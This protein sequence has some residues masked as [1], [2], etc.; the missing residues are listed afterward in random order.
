MEWIKPESFKKIKTVKVDEERILIQIDL[1]E[2]HDNKLKENIFMYWLEDGSVQFHDKSL[3]K[4]SIFGLAV[5][6]KNLYRG[7]V[8]SSYGQ[9][10]LTFRRQKFMNSF[11][12]LLFYQGKTHSDGF[13]LTHVNESDKRY[14]RKQKLN[15]LDEVIHK[16][17]MPLGSGSLSF[18]YDSTDEDF[19]NNLKIEELGK[20]NNALE[21]RYFESLEMNRTD[22]FNLIKKKY[23]E[24]VKKYHPD[25][26]T[27][28]DRRIREIKMQEI[29]EAYQYF[30][31][32]F[33]NS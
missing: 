2:F 12:I 11:A 14:I 26:G 16:I 1:S 18:L 22:D 24:M 10:G 13:F 6:R 21:D 30:E 15:L 33:D 4:A 3:V 20:D 31:G 9:L 23:R 32:K 8:F 17:G 27:E 25:L 5:L 19:W 28:N 7:G 29:N